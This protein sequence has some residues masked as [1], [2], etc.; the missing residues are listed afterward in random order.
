MKNIR[1]YVFIFILLTLLYSAVVVF[2]YYSICDMKNALIITLPAFSVHW[3]H[4]QALF[5]VQAML[6]VLFIILFIRLMTRKNRV[7][8]EYRTIERQTEEQKLNDYADE[9]RKEDDLKIQEVVER[10]LDNSTGKNVKTVSEKVFINISKEYD[11]VQGLFFVFDKSSEKF[12]PSGR[13]AYY[14]Q[15][16]PSEFSVGEGIAGQV[17][18]DH[19]VLNINNLPDNYITILSGLGSSSPKHLLIIPFVLNGEA[20]GIMELASFQRFDSN[21]EAVFQLFA[22]Q[23]AT[24]I[25]E[26]CI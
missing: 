10:M 15:Q 23:F 22:E 21:A 4:I 16:E 3:L 26:F 25:A 18:K 5:I 12:R 20:I 6:A 1:R 24:K 7:K 2:L 9:K 13:Y 19:K 11:I 8:I 14:S 17:A